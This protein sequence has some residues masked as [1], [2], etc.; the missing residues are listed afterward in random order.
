MTENAEFTIGTHVS[1]TD[2]DGGQLRRVVVDPVSRK[3][4]HL[5]VEPQEGGT[6]RLVPVETVKSTEGGEIALSCTR[7]QLNAME[8]AEEVHFLSGAP[9]DWPYQP[10]Q[11]MSWPYY[12]LGLGGMSM[13]LGGIERGIGVVPPVVTDDNVPEGE[14][15]VRRG[16]SVHATDGDIGRVQGLIVD[17][18]NHRV[19]H[20]LLQEGHLWGRKDVA[21]PIDAVTKVAD[22]VQLRLS[23]DEVRD[24]P[25]VE[26]ERT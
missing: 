14:V 1:C 16:E 18:S 7:E 20:V 3:L 10:A 6:P 9:G 19:T 21:I 24:L 26:I 22:G 11:M 13:G 25:E 12:S 17:P 23:K 5:V 2:G 8:E 4:T 15:E